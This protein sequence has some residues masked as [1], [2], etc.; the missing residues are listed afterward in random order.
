MV[1]DFVV[2]VVVVFV[3]VVAVVLLLLLLLL[4]CSR[5]NNHW[6]MPSPYQ[7]RWRCPAPHHRRRRRRR[8]DCVVPSCGQGTMAGRRE[9]RG[10]GLV[11]R[12]SSP[13]ARAC[14]TIYDCAQ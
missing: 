10:L 9:A 8:H 3:V 12:C 5:H 4:F 13:L 6:L 11:P 7:D 1:V 14:S 2:V